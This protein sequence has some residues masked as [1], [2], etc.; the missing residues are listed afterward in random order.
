MRAKIILLVAVIV[1]WVIVMYN[2]PQQN[3]VFLRLGEGT[4]HLRLAVS[5][6]E[7]TRGLGGVEKLAGNEG[8]FFI[9]PEDAPHAIWMKDMRIPIDIL[10]LS[11]DFSIVDA[12]ENVSPDSFPA[13][14]SPRTPARFV[15][16]LPA[17]AVRTFGIK[18]RSRVE[19]LPE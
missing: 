6:A 14:F 11:H 17:G 16:E 4:F 3:N 2:P 7:R 19:I 12:R 5:E 13:I 18:E 8:M 15:V 1:V 10:W 9:F